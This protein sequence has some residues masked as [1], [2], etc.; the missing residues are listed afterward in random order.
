MCFALRS[1]VDTVGAGDSFNAGFLHKF[2]LG[3]DIQDCLEY[4]NATA[5]LSRPVP[6]GTEAFRDRQAP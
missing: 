4:G 1:A 2:I 5:G 6:C 3:A